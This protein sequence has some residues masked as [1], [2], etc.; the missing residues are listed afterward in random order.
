VAVAWLNAD[1]SDPARGAIALRE[2]HTPLTSS[3]VPVHVEWPDTPI[4]VPVAVASDDREPV[5]AE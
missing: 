1:V 4:V 3:I 5:S 2:W